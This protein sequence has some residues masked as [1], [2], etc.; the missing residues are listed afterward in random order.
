[1]N[2]ALPLQNHVALHEA[3]PGST[4]QL[5]PWYAKWIDSKRATCETLLAEVT[6]Q[7]HL[8]TFLHTAKILQ[9]HPQLS[10]DGI[11][12]QLEKDDYFHP[13]PDD[14]DP[15]AL[16]MQSLKRDLVFA[17]VGWI[18]FLYVP[19]IEPSSSTFRISNFID[20]TLYLSTVRPHS[21]AKRKMPMFLKGFG[22]LLPLP[23]RE[24]LRSN[25][26]LSRQIQPSPSVSSTTLNGELLHTLGK[27]RIEWTETLP[28]HLQ[29]DIQFKKLY[30]FRYPSYCLSNIPT[31]NDHRQ[32]GL[33]SRSVLTRL[34]WSQ[35]HH[36]QAFN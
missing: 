34:V 29:L 5:G 24:I 4:Q 2:A 35:I 10:I 26:D 6:P 9:L 22:F 27:L 12:A 23:Q 31:R 15:D 14:T 30:L 8:K 32:A 17:M 19:E 20:E 36:F 33:E 13:Q 7:T 3:F 1:M 21:D 25:S 16:R 11:A 28:A 18:T